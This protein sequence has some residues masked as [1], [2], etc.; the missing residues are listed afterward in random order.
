VLDRL[1]ELG[2]L[3]ASVALDADALG[4]A[5][6]A[7]RLPPDVSDAVRALLEKKYYPHIALHE[8]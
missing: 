4:A 6:E 8:E 3:P 2:M 5:L 1:V 7:G